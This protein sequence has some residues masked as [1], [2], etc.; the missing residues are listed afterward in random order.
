MH[1]LEFSFYITRP[2]GFLF[3][4]CCGLFSLSALTISI[5]KSPPTFL[6]RFL[7]RLGAWARLAKKH[8]YIRADP[9]GWSCVALS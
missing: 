7:A 6:A 4:V 1:R 8:T 2:V 9:S 5:Y 3:N